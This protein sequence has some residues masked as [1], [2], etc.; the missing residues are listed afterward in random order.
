M[1]CD[2]AHLESKLYW[3]IVFS[4]YSYTSVRI[5]ITFFK[6]SEEQDNLLSFEF[7]VNVEVG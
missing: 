6:K 2:I 5:G 3:R 1:N 4:K 7:A